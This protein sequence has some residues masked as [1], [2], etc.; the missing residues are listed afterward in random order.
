MDLSSGFGEIYL[1]IFWSKFFNI[2][3]SKIFGKIIFQ[4]EFWLKYS[5]ILWHVHIYFYLFCALFY[6][7]FIILMC[8]PFGF[9][10]KS[11][12]CYFVVVN[13]MYSLGNRELIISFEF[14]IS[15][16][17]NFTENA[18]TD[19]KIH[20]TRKDSLIRGPN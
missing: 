9:V 17:H 18:H 14:Y 11:F 7:N 3:Q 13:Q 6:F 12:G 10:L 16:Y 5:L 1:N 20:I 8:L 15:E 2:S 19:T 4:N